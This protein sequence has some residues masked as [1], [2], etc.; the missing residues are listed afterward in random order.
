M[1][2]TSELTI[3]PVIVDKCCL[4]HYFTGQFSNYVG[5]NCGRFLALK[6][7]VE[8]CWEMESREQG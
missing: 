6:T 5:A 8:Q 7:P 2:N 3:N 4:S 1:V